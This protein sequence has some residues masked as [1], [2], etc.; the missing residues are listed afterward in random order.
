M[1]STDRKKVRNDDCHRRS[2]SLEVIQVRSL[3]IWKF[4]TQLLKIK[5]STPKSS[6]STTVV[7][8]AVRFISEKVRND[9]VI[10]VRSLSDPAFT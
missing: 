10:Q 7:E 5:K 3:S 1:A 9:E 4:L 2:L 6:S 8:C